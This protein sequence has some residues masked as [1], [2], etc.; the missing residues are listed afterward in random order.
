MLSRQSQL[1]IVRHAPLV[2]I[3][4]VIE[5]GSGNVLVG[6]R[7]N[8]PAMGCWF[9]PGGRVMKDE[10]LDDA[11][12]RILKREV[13]W[14]S[15]RGQAQF[16]GAYEHFYPANFAREP[17]ITTHYV[18]LAYKIVVPNRPAVVGDD[19]HE[20]L[21]WMSIQTLLA[22]PDVHENTKVYYRGAT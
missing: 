19:Q 1:E 22:H 21:E 6:K 4:L 18:A 13:G 9:V 10:R 15:A 16:L 3:D 5:D 11:F 20:Q 17:G 12:L 14:V 2:S 8:E 7:V